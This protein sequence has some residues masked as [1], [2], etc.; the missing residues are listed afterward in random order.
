LGDGAQMNR[1]VIIEDE[2]AISRMLVQ[3]FRTKGYEVAAAF[4]GEEG[5]MHLREQPAAIVVIDVVL[6][7]IH[8]LEVLKQARQ[9]QPNARIVVVTGLEQDDLREKAHSYGAD[10][11]VTKPFSFSNPTWVAALGLSSD[12]SAPPVPPSA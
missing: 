9:L 4:S 2:Q 10:A 8:G 5:L 11:Y 1:V 7:G 3:F 6:P 12:P